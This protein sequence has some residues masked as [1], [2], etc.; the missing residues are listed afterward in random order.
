MSSREE[1]NLPSPA[2]DDIRE[3]LKQHVIENMLLNRSLADSAKNYTVQ[4]E[5][6]K[7]ERGK[8]GKKRPH[9]TTD[10]EASGEFDG[11]DKEGNNQQKNKHKKKESPMEKDKE[12]I[13]SKRFE[14]REIGKV[15]KYDAFSRAA[16]IVYF[17]I[18][19]AKGTD[20][21]KKSVPILVAS[22]KLA[23]INIKFEQIVRYSFNIWNVTFQSKTM[24]NS[25]RTN[26]IL[27][28]VGL[29]AFI[30]RYKLRRKGVIREIPEDLSLKELKIIIHRRRN[31]QLDDI[32]SVLFETEKYDN[33]DKRRISVSVFGV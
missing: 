25:A 29:V 6:G 24:A 13:K 33:E 7:D 4:M 14:T 16:Y 17:R 31:L 10:E 12:G 5:V 23:S 18:T 28:E 2:Y 27:Q 3:D 19:T 30:L 11:L 8:S 22:K 9:P 26:P 21:S 15:D 20:G 32:R 1:G